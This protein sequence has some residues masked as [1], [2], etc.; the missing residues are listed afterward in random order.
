MA[1]ATTPSASL[2]DRMLRAARLDVPLYEEVEADTT[3]TTQALTVVVIVAS[4]VSTLQ[5]V[6]PTRG[7]SPANARKG[8]GRKWSGRAMVFR[9]SIPYDLVVRSARGP[10]G[11]VPLSRPSQIWQLSRRAVAS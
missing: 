3:A 11:L 10:L 2:P 9:G 7:A 6:S 4:F 8:L 5:P 1:L